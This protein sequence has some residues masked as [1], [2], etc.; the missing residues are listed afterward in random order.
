MQKALRI[1]IV[2]NRYRSAF[3]SGE[4]RVVDQESS[5]LRTAGHDVEVFQ[6]HSD[7]IQELPAVKKVLLP[8]TAVWS[9]SSA[10]IL[11]KVFNSFKPDVVHFHN[12]FRNYDSS[13]HD[14]TCFLGK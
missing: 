6:R 14:F 8:A 3:F 12:L 4:D 5:A 13:R 10:R 2:H 9:P 11:D 7:E 1:L